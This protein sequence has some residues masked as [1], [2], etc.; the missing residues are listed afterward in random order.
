M[1][2]RQFSEKLDLEILALPDPERPVTGGYAGDLLSWVMSRAQS[3]D[4]WVT[5]MT[6]V[7]IIA[8]AQ[9]ADTACVVVAEGQPV[10]QEVIDSVEAV[11][12][13]IIDGKLT[14]PSTLDDVASFIETYCNK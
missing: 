3:G 11:K 5:I 4:F 8:V 2:V 14:V 6:N 13:E 1:T 7:N 10:P 12:Q 9:M